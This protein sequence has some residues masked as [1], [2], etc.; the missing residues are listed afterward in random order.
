MSGGSTLAQV[1]RY[2]PQSSIHPIV[3]PARGSIGNHVEYQA[4]YIAANVAEKRAVL[5]G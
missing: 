1:A 2:L 3:V 4:N 5:T